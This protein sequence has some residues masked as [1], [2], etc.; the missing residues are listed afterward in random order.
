[1]SL[2]PQHLEDLGYCASCQIPREVK[3]T[4][5]AG[6]AFCPQWR[7]SSAL[8]S[9]LPRPRLSNLGLGE[10]AHKPGLPR[11]GVGM[12]PMPHVPLVTRTFCPWAGEGDK[13][14]SGPGGRE[15]RSQPAVGSFSESVITLGTASGEPGPA[16]THTAAAP[17]L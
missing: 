14:R 2:P 1:M 3:A 17:L 8:G 12:E 15:G 5:L 11:T 16:V 4:G 13:L 7:L 10:Q 6:D 9:F